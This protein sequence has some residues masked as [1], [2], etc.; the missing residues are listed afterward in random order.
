[1][2][3][4]S[5]L[6]SMLSTTEIQSPTLNEIK[7]LTLTD[8]VIM[9]N[10]S[11]SLREQIKK[12]VDIDPFTTDDPFKEK[13]DYEYSVILDKTNTNRVISIL[14]TIK[15]T[16]IQ[17]PWESILGSQFIRLSI[18]KREAAALKHELMPKDTNNFYPFRKS[19]RIAG[20]IMFAFQICGLQQ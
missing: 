14:V 15:E 10:L 2:I 6:Q 9:N 18:S 4:L 12:Y 19:T 1:M 3:N 5:V 11:V 13:D 20:Y 17:L 7:T 16:S 8:L